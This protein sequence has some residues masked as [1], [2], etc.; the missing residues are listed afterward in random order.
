MMEENVIKFIE[1]LVNGVVAVPLIV[2]LYNLGVI[3]NTNAWKNIAA[4]VVPF[5][6]A[7]VG[8]LAV[9]WLGIMELPAP[10]FG[11]WATFL[12]PVFAA[13]YATSQAV[14]KAIWKPAVTAAVRLLGNAN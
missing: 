11:S 12:Y 10:T 3:P 5:V 6:L 13:A 7:F 4:F 14:Y 9:V 2:A 1:G 8:M